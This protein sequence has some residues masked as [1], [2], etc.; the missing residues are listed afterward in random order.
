M[1]RFSMH[2]PKALSFKAALK[3]RPQRQGKL[4]VAAFGQLSS[5][6][7]KN[8]PVWI[9]GLPVFSVYRVGF[10]IETVPPA[11]A[12]D[13]SPCGSCAQHG[14]ELFAARPNRSASVRLRRF[15]GS[16]RLPTLI[17]K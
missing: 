10:D 8:G 11:I 4:C 6:T 15:V 9:L 2:V 5:S 14:S 7:R 13:E 16:P 12:F 1:H 3:R 17:A